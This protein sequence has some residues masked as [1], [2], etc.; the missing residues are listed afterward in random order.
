MKICIKTSD[1]NIRFYLPTGLICNRTI[2]RIANTIGRK[3]ASDS[4]KDISPEALET[5]FVE[6]G[7]IKKHYGRWELV[8][9]ESAD[10]V[11]VEVIL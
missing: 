11:L 5:L 3:Y 9:V 6:M 2:A 4:L 7:R 8:T 1:Q 10:G